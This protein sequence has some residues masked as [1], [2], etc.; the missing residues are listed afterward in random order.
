MKKLFLATAVAAISLNTVAET[1]QFELQAAH[2]DSE[3][4]DTEVKTSA[5]AGAYYLAPVDDSVGAKAEAA[6][7]NKSSNIFLSYSQIEI[8][9]DPL[10]LDEDGTGY[11]AGGEY[12]LDSGII[13][14][15]LYSSSEIEDF[16]SETIGV[17]VGYYLTD[18]STIDLRFSYIDDDLEETNT[19]S[20]G[21]KNVLDFGDDQSLNVEAI[22][23]HLDPDETD[24][25]T[26]LTVISDYYFTSQ[27]SAGASVGYTD[28]DSEEALNYGV[29]GSYFFGSNFALAIAY[30]VT[31]YDD[32]S[33]DLETLSIAVTGRF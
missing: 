33:D 32:L 8:E 27:L 5:L 26:N 23:N 12:V 1:F 16:D 24:S 13:L 21:Y 6:F 28:S 22:L 15:A 10:L 2:F 20:L 4:G 30:D 29:K 7:L 25:S 3:L 19:F 11:V 18:S 17:G 9:N 14:S 31:D